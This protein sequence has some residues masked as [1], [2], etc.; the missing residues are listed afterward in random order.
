M[1]CV[2]CRA[3]EPA[4]STLSLVR[5]ISS[6]TSVMKVIVDSQCFLLCLL[7]LEYSS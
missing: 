6:C 5:R 3:I 2:Y 4:M 1:A 7:P